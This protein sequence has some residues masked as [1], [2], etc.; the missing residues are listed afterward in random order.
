LVLVPPHVV[1]DEGDHVS[2]KPALAMR[3]VERYPS[4]P[5]A[6]RGQDAER[7]FDQEGAPI[8]RAPLLEVRGCRVGDRS[9]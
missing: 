1:L 4:N 3:E 2:L 8:D 5:E 9:Q 6:R 7:A